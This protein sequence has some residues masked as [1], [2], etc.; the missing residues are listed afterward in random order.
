MPTPPSRDW[1]TPSN[2]WY[3]IVQI[4]IYVFAAGL[5]ADLV[6]VLNLSVLETYFRT[7]PGSALY[8]LKFSSLQWALL[9]LTTLK[10]VV[11]IVLLLAIVFRRQWNC[12]VF[13]FIVLQI[14]EQH[15]ANQN[16]NKKRTQISKIAHVPELLRRV[17]AYPQ[18][19]CPRYPPSSAKNIPQEIIMKHKK[20]PL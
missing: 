17:Q 5:V 14:K 1:Y 13:W 10:Y 9:M 4:V 15:K 18:V 11:P 12:S 6:Q 16:N 20:A 8:T 19:L 7:L 3:W 2:S